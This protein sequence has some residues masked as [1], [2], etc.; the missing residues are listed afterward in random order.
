MKPP[1]SYVQLVKQ[2]SRAVASRLYD[3]A[4][5]QIFTVGS[6]RCMYFETRVHNG[7]SK[8]S[9]VTEDFGTNQK[10]VC[11]FLLVINSSLGPIL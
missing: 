11:N 3:A 1:F 2:E 9:K 4:I 5:I 10:C 8:L 7:H 6:E